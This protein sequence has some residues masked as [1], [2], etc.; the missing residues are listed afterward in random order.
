MK[1]GDIETGF[2]MEK[3]KALLNI[4]SLTSEECK[5]CWAFN[6][7]TLCAKF[8]D[9]GDKLSASHK[10]TNCDNTRRRVSNNLINMILLQEAKTLYK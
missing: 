1:I 3:A 9:D 4:G 7:C 8:A 2:D 6:R 5:N 10:L